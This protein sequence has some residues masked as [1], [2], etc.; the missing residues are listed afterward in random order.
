[1]FLNCWWVYLVVVLIGCI[2][3]LGLDWYYWGCNVGS[4]NLEK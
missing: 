1:M 4:L 3:W 2:S